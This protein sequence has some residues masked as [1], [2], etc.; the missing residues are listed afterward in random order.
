M[1]KLKARLVAMGYSEVKG[2]DFDKGF[3][4]T[5]RMETLRLIF[6]LLAK[7]KWVGWQ[8]YFKTAFF[9]GVLDEVVYM[10]QAPGFEDP[11]HPD[12][13]YKL[14]KSIYS[15][16]QLPRQ[17]NKELHAAL[18]KLGL[19]QSCYDPTLYFKMG[20]RELVGVIT[21]HVDDLPVVGEPQFAHMIQ[22]SMPK[23]VEISS[24]ESL[25]HFFSIKITYDLSKHTVCTSQEHYI[26]DLKTRLLSDSHISVVTPTDMY[27]KDLMSCTA[28]EKPSPGPYSSIISAL[29]WVAQC[30]RANIS[31]TVD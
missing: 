13:V 4:P 23:F 18:L 6:T 8:L 19:Q 22:S 11:D 26:D 16:K 21:S 20:K 30:T 3:A 7:R 31:F 28:E 27:F 29:L 2:E 1:A 10:E 14:Y 9:N 12:R 24:D 25:H 17:W 15:L 5:L